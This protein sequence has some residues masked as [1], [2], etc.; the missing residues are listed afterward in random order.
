MKNTWLII[1]F[2]I[3][4]FYAC[5]QSNDVESQTQDATDSDASLAEPDSS[6][7]TDAETATH[8]R[9]RPGVET[10]TILESPPGIAV[11]LISP[12]GDD[13]ITL[14]TDGL[15]QAHFAY[16][17]AEYQS[18]ESSGTNGISFADALVITPGDGYRLRTIH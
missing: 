14:T 9:F 7:N 15:G 18:L 1:T 11:T 16:V 12:M 10:V 4:C 8:I 3:W 17:T 6:A 5:T 2:A 13:L